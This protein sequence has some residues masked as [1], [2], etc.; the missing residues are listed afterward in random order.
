[1]FY[2]KWVVELKKKRNILEMS[3]LKKIRVTYTCCIFLIVRLHKLYEFGSCLIVNPIEIA[4]K[5][6]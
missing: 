3:E 4:K 5:I 1:M 2:S 6:F